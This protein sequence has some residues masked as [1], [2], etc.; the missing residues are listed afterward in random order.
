MDAAQRS[1]SPA[2]DWAKR[3]S[4]K[5]DFTAKVSSKFAALASRVQTVV[6]QVF[7]G[8]EPHPTVPN[9]LRPALNLSQHFKHL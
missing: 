9:S 2:C 6:R 3:A 8:M 4:I 1:V 7:F 5:I